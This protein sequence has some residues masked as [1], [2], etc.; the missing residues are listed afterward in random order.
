MLIAS[1]T[2]LARKPA[3]LSWEAAA[4]FPVPALTATQ[5]IDRALAVRPDDL[6]LVNGGSAVTG[7]LLVG[8]AAARGRPPKCR[9]KLPRR[10]P[11]A[12]DGSYGYD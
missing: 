10:W 11:R 12:P 2:V 4:A 5:V 3:A 1:A 7:T 6:V 9:C 8:L